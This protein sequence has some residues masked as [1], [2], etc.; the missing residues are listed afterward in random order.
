[1]YC[2]VLI[3]VNNYEILQMSE[4]NGKQSEMGQLGPSI[5][6]V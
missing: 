4:G 2:N 5:F 1:M 6:Y 3:Q